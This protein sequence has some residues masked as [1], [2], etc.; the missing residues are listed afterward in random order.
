MLPVGV[1]KGH[2]SAQSPE[3]RVVATHERYLPLRLQLRRTA[4]TPSKT[5][6]QMPSIP[7][8]NE[9]LRIA[10]VCL[11]NSGVSDA[12]CNSLPDGWHL[13]EK[14]SRQLAYS[15]CVHAYLSKP[16]LQAAN[17]FSDKS[18]RRPSGPL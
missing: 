16:L 11:H 1:L 3:R 4:P 12:G 15:H 17:D 2:R 8:H 18:F 10:A 6:I 7:R 5:R 14:S 13:A 9:S